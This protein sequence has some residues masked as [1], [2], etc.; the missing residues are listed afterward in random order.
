MYSTKICIHLISESANNEEN[1][2]L[3]HLWSPPTYESPKALEGVENTRYMTPKSDKIVNHVHFSYD[4][5]RP[6]IE[7]ATIEQ[8]LKYENEV[9]IRPKPITRNLYINSSQPNLISADLYD[10]P[11]KNP[12]R[13]SYLDM[14]KNNHFS[15]AIQKKLSKDITFRFSSVENVK[16]TEA[17]STV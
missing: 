17:T 10:S 12:T 14:N 11:K 7:A 16:V 1:E 3:E 4:V 13:V 8:K 15:N 9:T 6:L 5:P 2:R